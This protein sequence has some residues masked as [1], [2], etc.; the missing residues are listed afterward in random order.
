[1]SLLSFLASSF[2]LSPRSLLDT[3]SWGLSLAGVLVCFH[4]AVLERGSLHDD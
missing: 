1:M 4:E 3:A 2:H